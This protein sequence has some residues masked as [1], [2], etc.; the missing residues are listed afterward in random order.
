MTTPA[1][2]RRPLTGKGP[3]TGWAKGAR[4]ALFATA[5]LLLFIGATVGAQ[6]PAQ[7]GGDQPDLALVGAFLIDG[8]QGPPLPNSVVLVQG[9]RIIHVGTTVNTPVPAGVEVVD[10]RGYTLMPGLNDAHVHLMIVGHGVYGEWF[11]EYR[12]RFRELMAISARQLL[13]AGVTTARDLGAPLD[14]ILWLR[15]QINAGSIPGPRLF[16]SGPFLQKTTGPSQAF[17]RWTV[18]G[19]EDAAQ[20]ARQL[21]EAGVD[22]LKVIQVDQL[23]PD[24]REAIAAEARR[25]GM[26]IAAHGYTSA[27]LRAAVEMGAHS[28]EH[29]N[30]RP[31]PLYPESDL[32]LMSQHGVVAVPSSIVSQVYHRTEAFPARLDHPR[33]R[34]DFPQ[35]VHAAILASLENPSRLG[36]F[37]DKREVSGF[38]AAKIR[39]MRE[40]GVRILVGTDS[41][42]PMNFHYESAWQEMELL[43]E[44]G[45]PPMEVIAGATHW[46][47]LLYGRGDDLGT[48]EPGKLADL[49]VVDGNP[50]EHMRALRDVVHVF[51]GGQQVVVDGQLVGAVGQP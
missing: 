47:A 12:P 30:A 21:I 44:Y 35:D 9:E 40:A 22:L 8:T 41:G 33:L 10:L 31:L 16:V 14:D 24:E 29:V 38:H 46:P 11:E 6:I 18:D 50:L 49:L 34:S 2:R 45:L 48:I 17:F 42:T 28:I 4:P 3:G 32:R 5:I 15:N 7:P 1:D 43:V 27:E 20:K 19:P 37:T 25:A 39:Q 36:Y 13:E 23:S 51:K 26:H